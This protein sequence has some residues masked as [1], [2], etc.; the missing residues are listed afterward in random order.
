MLR[1]SANVI[2]NFTFIGVLS[3][4]MSGLAVAQED[5]KS[6]NYWL[7]FCRQ[8]VEDKLN[9]S[10]AFNDGACVGFITGLA[11]LGRV[12]GVCRPEGSTPEQAVRVVIQYLDQRPARTNEKFG[13]LALE[14]LSEAWPCKD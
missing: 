14:A 10:D 12:V 1:R 3:G 13:T 4:T 8:V 7:P 9:Q 2:L 5:Q 6:A 11:S